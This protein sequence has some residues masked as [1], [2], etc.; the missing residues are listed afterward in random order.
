MERLFYRRRFKDW[1]YTPRDVTELKDLKRL[2]FTTYRGCASNLR[3]VRGPLGRGE[4]TPRGD[5]TIPRV[6]GYYA[7]GSAHLEKP[8]AP[9]SCRRGDRMDVFRYPSLRIAHRGAWD[10]LGGRNDRCFGAANFV[11]RRIGKSKSCRIFG[12]RSC[13]DPSYA[14]VIADQIERMKLDPSDSPQYASVR[15]NPGPRDAAD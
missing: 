7:A 9:F 10:T 11:G 1:I 15:A 8:G 6:V 13:L 2:A 5:Q 14:L 12:P 3:D 4:V